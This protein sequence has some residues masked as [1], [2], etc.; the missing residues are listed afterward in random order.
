MNGIRVSLMDAGRTTLQ[1]GQTIRTDQGMAELL[2]T[3]G[4][5][6]RLGE[7]SDLT[8]E[9]MDPS[10]VRASLGRGEA[11]LEV[12]SLKT[13]ISLEEDGA[14]VTIRKPG[15]YGF[16]LKRG[17]VNV[18]TGEVQI[19]RDGRQVVADKG[20]SARARNLRESPLQIDPGDSLYGWSNNRDRLL[21]TE[22]AAAAG[23]SAGTAAGPAWAWNPWSSSYTFLSASGAVTGPFG[24]PYYSP[25]YA[26]NAIP[27]HR[28]GDSWLYG[29]PVLAVPGPVQMPSPGP[30]GPATVPLTAP[31]VPQ[32]PGSRF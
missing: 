4:S 9:Q 21:S 31:G 18:Y 26:P 5:F 12:L 28:G 13:P 17:L 23:S 25:G 10:G 24:W 27:E 16:N 7:G 2:L 11:L 30:H 8:L 22:S 19:E 14:T 6:L 15:L 20:F 32:F 3:P 1:P 29:P